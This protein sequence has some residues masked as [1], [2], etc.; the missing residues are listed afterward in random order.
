MRKDEKVEY[1]EKEKIAF[2][3]IEDC[4]ENKRKKLG[5][6]EKEI[7][8]LIKDRIR[9]LT[10][11]IKE[12][13][14]ILRK[15]DV[16]S[17]KVEDRLKY[18]VKEARKEYIDLI[19]SF[20]NNLDNLKENKL[21]KIIF[22]ID[23]L[24]L[25]FNRS[26]HLSYERTTILIGKEM[27]DIKNEL[28]LFSKELIT[29]F[30]ENKEIT[31]SFETI[32]FIESELKQFKKIKEE[33]DKTNQS[34][35]SIDQKII[36]KEEH[37]K[38][39]LEEIERIKKNP[40]Y[41]EYLKRLEKVKSLEID[42]EKDVQL[43]RQ[44]IDFKTL[45]AFFHIFENKMKI[46]N[47]Y[48]ENFQKNFQ[49]DDGKEIWDLLKEAQLATERISDAIK[50]IN[51]KKEEILKNKIQNEKD[52]QIMQRL[53]SESSSIILEIDSLKKEKSQEQKRVK[54]LNG[55]EKEIINEINEEFGKIGVCVD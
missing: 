36:F 5:M 46:V 37:S 9:I 14:D 51:N 1:H 40:E 25:V 47:L 41:S 28:T 4:I 16:E 17:K 38:K 22:N 30:K 12:K 35:T 26:S 32:Y 29:L 23:T 21:E 11:R 13:I 3:D 15:V 27:E 42:L 18:V 34:I 49:Q 54:N 8:A 44:L 43:L 33:T 6:R 19:E 53:Y 45:G 7:L 39:I 52:G 48:K 50:N 2:S 55:N 24:F 31:T 10:I 20:I